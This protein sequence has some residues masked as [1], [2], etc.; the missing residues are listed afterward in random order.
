M[1]ALGVL[2]Y[3]DNLSP[4]HDIPVFLFATDF[5]EYPPSR[6]KVSILYAQST[7]YV[8]FCWR[9]EEFL[10]GDCDGR[11]RRP[12]NDGRTTTPMV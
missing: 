11:L 7:K 2:F 10:Q 1:E 12:R 4:G 9:Q 5:I 3:P 6:L 8:V